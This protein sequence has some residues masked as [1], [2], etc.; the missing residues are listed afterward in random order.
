M[1]GREVFEE[2]QRRAILSDPLMVQNR[3]SEMWIQEKMGRG[4]QILY[5]L[6]HDNPRYQKKEGMFAGIC[7]CSRNY[8]HYYYVTIRIRGNISPLL[9][10]YIEDQAISRIA[11]KWKVTKKSISNMDWLDFSQNPMMSINDTNRVRNRHDTRSE[12]ILRRDD[13]DRENA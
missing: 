13:T 8:E 10:A 3:D 5:S 11:R 1:D 9:Q 2:I 6:F 4:K 12:R 7:H